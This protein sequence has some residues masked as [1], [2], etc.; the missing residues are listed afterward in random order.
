MG[1]GESLKVTKTQLRN[2]IIKFYSKRILLVLDD[3]L[4]INSGRKNEDIQN[5]DEA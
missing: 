4:R 3:N 1:Q 2:K 5:M